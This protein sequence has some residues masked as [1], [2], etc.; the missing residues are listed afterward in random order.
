LSLDNI[1]IV[2]MNRW[3]LYFFIGL[4]LLFMSC[5]S[6]ESSCPGESISQLRIGFTRETDSTTNHFIVYHPLLADSIYDSIVAPKYVDVP[7]DVTSDSMAVFI[8]FIIAQTDSTSEIKVTDVVAITYKS[9]SYIENLDCGVLMDFEIEEV[10]YTHNHLDTFYFR[11]K[12]INS[13]IVDHVEIS[14]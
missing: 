6:T 10:Y 8:D 9:H 12:D 5:N 13:E 4:G 3:I 7:M 1:K 11:N 14:Y 2:L